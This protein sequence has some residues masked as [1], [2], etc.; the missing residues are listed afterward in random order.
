MI[1]Q[2]IASLESRIARLESS[3]NRKKAFDAPMEDI[4]FEYTLK[5]FK[6]IFGD[7]DLF[8]IDSFKK[9]E[10]YLAGGAFIIDFCFGKSNPSIV[11]VTYNNMFSGKVKVQYGIPNSIDG[12]DSAFKVI[13]ADVKSRL[14]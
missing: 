4:F 2:K 13:L 8:T 9:N 3:L 7:E 11:N 14:G 12:L 10:I 6:H 1:N 5:Q